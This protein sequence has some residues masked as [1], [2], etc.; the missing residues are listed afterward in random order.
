[1]KYRAKH[2]IEYI[3]IRIVVGI[4]R[5]LPYIGALAVGWILA[6]VA[7]WFF[8]A[9]AQNAIT[10]ITEVFG[11]KLNEEEIRRIA[12]LSWRNFVFSVIDMARLRRINMKWI[13][14][15][16]IEWEVARDAIQAQFRAGKGAII[17]CPHVGAWELGGVV[18]QV[19]GAPMFFFAARQKNPLVNEFMNR[20]RSSTGVSVIERD[21][22][23]LRAVIKRLRSGDMLGFLPD[24]RSPSGGV[25]VEFLDRTV[26]VPA[27]MAMFAYHAGV[28]I[29]PSVAIRVGWTRHIIRFYDPIWPDMNKTKEENAQAMTQQ[30]FRHYD[31][32]IR[33]QP[34]QWF[35]FNR[36]WIF[37]PPP[38]APQQELTATPPTDPEL[39]KALSEYKNDTLPPG[40]KS[41]R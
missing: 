31:A 38:L 28:P 18:L 3:F 9:R 1:M 24:V 33:Q 35:W 5:S 30:A 27:G 20:M 37:E 19:F 23:A 29:I 41:L 32:I 40:R 11:K 26:T 25:T 39:D 36:R 14:S 13:R 21:P 12:W 8:K 7:S 4:V 17:A 2:V 34:E 22:S 10:R 16:V 15:N 6:K